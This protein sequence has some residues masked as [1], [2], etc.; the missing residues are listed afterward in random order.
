[1]NRHD[2]G[3]FWSFL[4]WVWREITQEPKDRVTVENFTDEAYWK[5]KKKKETMSEEETVEKKK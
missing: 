3:S 1:M 5:A 2:P 4:R